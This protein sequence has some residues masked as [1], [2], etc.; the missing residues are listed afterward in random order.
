MFKRLDRYCYFEFL[1]MLMIGTT[2]PAGILFFSD[3][4]RLLQK[5]M[6]QFGCPLDLYILM[7]TMQLPDIIVHCLP[8]GVL[9]GTML[10]LYRMMADSEII[11]LQTSGVSLFRIFQPF[12]IIGF[13]VGL[14]AFMVNELVVPRSLKLSTKLAILAASRV[15]LPRSRGINDFKAVKKDDKGKVREVY[16]IASREGNKLKNACLLRFPED[17]NGVKLVYAPTGV[18]KRASWYLFNGHEYD[19]N[20]D[21]TESIRN[22]YFQ[23]MLINPPDFSKLDPDKREPLASEMN[24]LELISFIQKK[25]AQGEK[26]SIEHYL[27]LNYNLASPM[28]CVFLVIATFPIALIGR[29]RR[30]T[31][32]GLAY[33]GSLIV[34]YFTIDQIT[35]S[36]A[37]NNLIDPILAVWAPGVTIAGMGM[38]LMAWVMKNR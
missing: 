30:K 1:V 29:R 16:L 27:N 36:L 24:T 23:K 35:W 3:K 31:A 37:K 5:Y 8:A 32:I 19:L 26:A 28:S 14:F 4:I 13:C 25:K 11:C 20:Q 2:L 7:T 22:S 18:F 15:D 21:E 9:I 6:S 33:A 34:I 38:I 10:V 12:L 17:F